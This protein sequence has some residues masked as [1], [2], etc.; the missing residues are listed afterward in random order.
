M[1]RDIYPWGNAGLIDALPVQCA[2]P[3]KQS[4]HAR[5]RG[6]QYAH[7]KTSAMRQIDA[8]HRRHLIQQHPVAPLTLLAL[9]SLH[10]C[11]KIL[12]VDAAL[13]SELS[14]LE[15]SLHDSMKTV[16]HW[17]GGTT[18]HDAIVSGTANTWNI[19]LCIEPVV[20]KSRYFDWR[21]TLLPR[22]SHSRSPFQLPQQRRY[23]CT[24]ALSGCYYAGRTPSQ[25]VTIKANTHKLYHAI[26]ATQSECYR[27][28]QRQVRAFRTA[29]K[30]C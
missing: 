3:R 12:R 14:I 29:S 7:T 8:L 5:M 22:H 13:Q 30:T 23:V 17:R 19:N 21:G 15:I 6:K 20:V 18:S 24:R 25:S 27:G 1:C 28:A 4:D 9:V 10:P 2:G 16:V 11:D 26:K